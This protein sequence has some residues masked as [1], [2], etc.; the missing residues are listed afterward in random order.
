MCCTKPGLTMYI[1]ICCLTQTGNVT[2]YITDPS[3]RQRGRSWQ[4][5]LQLS[6]LQPEFGHKSR[7]GSTP[8]EL[9]DWLTDWP[10][11]VKWLWLWLW[12]FISISTHTFLAVYS[13]RKDFIPML[14]GSHVT[15]IWHVLGLRNEEKASRY[16]GQLRIYWI[17]SRGQPTNGLGLHVKLKPLIAKI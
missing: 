3:S 11:V 7:R 4:T 12:I 2:Y 15:M 16:W 9:T 1:C 13:V 6:L 10:S 17:S 5:K 14:V 8:R